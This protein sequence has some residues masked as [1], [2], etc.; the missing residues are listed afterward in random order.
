MDCRVETTRYGAGEC[1]RHT[2]AGSPSGKAASRTG[3][4]FP[5]FSPVTFR[6]FFTVTLLPSA[7]VT[8]VFTN[9]QPSAF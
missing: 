7:A 1:V 9:F 4:Y 3:P 8:L 5:P 6:L 2:E